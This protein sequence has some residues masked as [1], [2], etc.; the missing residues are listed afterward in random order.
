MADKPVI[1]VSDLLRL[2]QDSGMADPLA[3][4]G[5]H[6]YAVAAM[7]VLRGLRRAD[8]LKVLRRMRRI[9]WR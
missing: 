2:Q 3:D 8:K 4:E 5:V 7:V 9:M 6:D 1:Q